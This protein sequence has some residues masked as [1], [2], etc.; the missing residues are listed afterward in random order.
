[1]IRKSDK[2]DVVV[3]AKLGVD[4]R[5]P[6]CVGG[7]IPGLPANKNRSLLF[8][9]VTVNYLTVLAGIQ[10]VS[11]THVVSTLTGL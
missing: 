10:T 3:I 11:Q 8:V 7:L 4:T 1:M 5:Q 2:K 6:L 9:P